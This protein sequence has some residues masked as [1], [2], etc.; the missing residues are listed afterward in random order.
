MKRA[1]LICLTLIGQLAACTG[2]PAT[3]DLALTIEAPAS[4]RSYAP[5]APLAE[6]DS[7]ESKP[8]AT[9]ATVQVSLTNLATDEVL[10]LSTPI[11]QQGRA[12]FN[13]IPVGDYTIYVS[14]IA[15]SKA[16][17][18]AGVVT[19]AVG[20][21]QINEISLTLVETGGCPRP[22]PPAPTT[23]AFPARSSCV[24]LR[25][26][27]FKSE[28]TYVF[29]VGE[30]V[31]ENIG[32]ADETTWFYDKRLDK[33]FF[34]FKSVWSDDKARSLKSTDSANIT[35]KKDD[36]TICFNPYNDSSRHFSLNGSNVALA[37]DEPDDPN[38]GETYSGVVWY[39]YSKRRTDAP[40]GTAI[41]DITQAPA[42][43]DLQICSAAPGTDNCGNILLPSS[44]PI[45]LEAFSA[46][47]TSAG[48]IF[49]SSGTVEIR[50]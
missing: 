6:T 40:V 42:N 29:L 13:D 16:E 36:S 1:A 4:I 14:I 45:T 48:M 46:I 27:G 19:E 22:T 15:L 43:S 3:G 41:T 17:V 32:E 21:D 11:A 9:L 47:S 2:A 24:N 50:E 12:E 26:S 35:A 23:L 20:A 8:C 10:Q 5:F 44:R 30:T 31:I 37:W 25:I 18:Y 38:P 7:T 33:D 49:R 28:G 34:S 39:Q